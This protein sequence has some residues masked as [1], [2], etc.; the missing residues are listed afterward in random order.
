MAL[1]VQHIAIAFRLTGAAPDIYLGQ[2]LQLD[3]H[4]VFGGQILGQTLRCAARSYGRGDVW[5]EDGSL[6]A[7][8]TQE[9]MIRML[10]T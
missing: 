6:V 3:Y 8:F 9:S 7:S 1:T 2:N 10:P 5:T 4:R